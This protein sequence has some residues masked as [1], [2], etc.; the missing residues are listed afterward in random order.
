LTL[1]TLLEKAYGSYTAGSFENELKSLCRGLKVRVTVQ[2][3]AAT[4]WIQIEL[5][6]DDESAARQILDREIGFALVSADRVGKFMNVRGKIFDSGESANELHVDIGVSNPNLCSVVI[7][8]STLRAQLMDGRNVA[9][10]HAVDLYC[11]YDHVPLQVKILSELDSARSAWRAELSEA[12]LSLFSNWLM[13]NLDRLI[14]LGSNRVEVEATIQG[15]GHLR[16][17]VRIESLGPLEHALECKLGTDA[18]GLM[19]KLGRRLRKAALL[20]FNPVII[21]KELGL[22]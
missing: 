10:Q 22:Q 14:V 1:L 15:V 12:Q 20:P 21:K 11:L 3:K 17:I 9:L 18:V 13:T 8:L 16:D 7:P 2:G 5:Q 19:P 4:G 6:G